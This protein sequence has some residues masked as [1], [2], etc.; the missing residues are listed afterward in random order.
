MVGTAD[1]NIGS[2]NVRER[3][4]SD[5]CENNLVFNIELIG[6]LS[7]RIPVTCPDNDKPCIRTLLVNYGK[8]L[9]EVPDALDLVVSS[10]CGDDLEALSFKRKIFNGLTSLLTDVLCIEGI[11]YIGAPV[12]VI[13]PKELPHYFF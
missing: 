3:V 5:T 2:C 13:I 1:I 12:I 11:V 7:V 8:S 4:L 10:H 6:K 9:N